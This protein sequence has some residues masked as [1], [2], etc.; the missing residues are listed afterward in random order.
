MTHT[1]AYYSSGKLVG[2]VNGYANQTTTQ[3]NGIAY[4]N[5]SYPEDENYKEVPFD[6]YKVYLIN[7]DKSY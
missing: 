4:I 2:C 6:D 7:A 5:V 3:A 1:T